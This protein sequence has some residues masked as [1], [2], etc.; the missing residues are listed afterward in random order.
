MQS[1][2]SSSEVRRSGE[3]G[4]D[5]AEEEGAEAKKE[6]WWLVRAHPAEGYAITGWVLGRFIEFDV[7]AL[8]RDYVSSAGL[9]TTAWME[10]NRVKDSSA[11]LHSQYLLAGIK[12]AEGQPCD[13]SQIRVFTWGAQRMR[14]ETAYVEGGLCGK[15]P[16]EI[17]PPSEAGGDTMF[18][19]KDL[20]KSS[21]ENRKYRMHQT[22]VRKINQEG[23]AKNKPH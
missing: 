20:S 13:F 5:V 4:W 14:Y 10:L 21:A 16:V 18:S 3:G 15:L 11:N 1:C 8:L 9:R 23:L 12:G 22:I 7:P 17:V 6:D 19:F 2:A